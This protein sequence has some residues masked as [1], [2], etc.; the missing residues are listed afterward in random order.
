MGWGKKR[1]WWICL[2]PCLAVMLYARLEIS[3]YY[4]SVYIPPAAPT[5]NLA[6]EAKIADSLA[7]AGGHEIPFEALFGSKEAFLNWKDTF[8]KWYAD[9][10]DAIPKL[11]PSSYTILGKEQFNGLTLITIAFTFPPDSPLHN[12]PAGG[13][14]AIPDKAIKNIP[15]IAVHGH[16]ERHWGQ[17]P[18]DLFK[19]QKWPFELARSGYVVWAPVS[20]YHTEI[21]DFGET[22]GYPLVW[23]KII[24]EGMNYLIN[25]EILHT[26]EKTWI[27]SGLSSGA[28][29]GYALMAYRSDIK[30]GIFA[31]A[32]QNLDFLRREYRIKGHP[33]C[34]E[35]EGINSFSTVMALIAPRPMQF[36]TGRNDPFFPHGRAL[37]RQG[38][39]FSGTS[40][41][42]YS[43]E[44]G[45]DF[46]AVRS[47]YAMFNK[48]NYFSV[49][50]HD[51]GHEFNV[52]EALAFINKFN[53]ND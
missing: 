51:G 27:V 1:L 20:M 6:G 44:I 3:A 38:D 30:Y 8:Q 32:E 28:Q 53:E 22:F 34:W 37:E 2:V 26:P 40:R 50:I 16:E 13:I 25:K 7:S 39:Y 21:A 48:K 17:Y 24:S 15:V 12:K 18:L 29:T 43:T 10:I 46:L 33:N 9:R 36:Q 14:L 41:G 31:G 5:A 45:G 49:M 11:A 19:E 47:I 52:K 35:I 42:Q 23:V 4:K